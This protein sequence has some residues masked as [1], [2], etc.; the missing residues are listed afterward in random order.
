[1]GLFKS[2]AKKVKCF[3]LNL[4]NIIMVDCMF[5]CGGGVLPSYVPEMYISLDRIFFLLA[6]MVWQESK[7]PECIQ[8]LF[9]RF[10]SA[11]FLSDAHGILSIMSTKKTNFNYFFLM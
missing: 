3:S 5:V 2:G 11:E 9:E 10:R 7:F 4:M 1:M 8:M 6:A